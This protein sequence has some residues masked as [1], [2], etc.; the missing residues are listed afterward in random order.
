[1]ISRNVPAQTTIALA[2]SLFVH[3]KNTV[4]MFNKLEIP[5]TCKLFKDMFYSRKPAL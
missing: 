1:M 4:V 5:L 3:E 2:N